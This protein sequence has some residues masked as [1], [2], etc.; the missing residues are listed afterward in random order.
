MYRYDPE[1]LKLRRIALELA[2]RR[3]DWVGG[4]FLVV[5]ER[6]SYDV[7]CIRVVPSM[8][9]R[10]NSCSG[11]KWSRADDCITHFSLDHLLYVQYACCT[12]AL[13][14]SARLALLL[15]EI[16]AARVVN[17]LLATS[18]MKPSVQIGATP[19][20][21]VCHYFFV[22]VLF[23]PHRCRDCRRHSR[24]LRWSSPQ[25]RY[26]KIYQ[27]RTFAGNITLFRCESRQFLGWKQA[28]IHNKKPKTK[29]FVFNPNLFEAIFFVCNHAVFSGSPCNHL[30]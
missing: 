27:S 13:K 21:A 7:W 4:C 15:T 20:R 24:N 22:L 25:Q 18:P 14:S 19:M 30:L 2:R 26:V 9:M 11:E 3:W 23:I 1:L 28:F 5:R 6:C 16:S 17:W 12:W 29:A 8:N 10:L